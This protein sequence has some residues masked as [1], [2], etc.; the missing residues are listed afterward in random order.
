MGK[1]N[2]T[3]LE[4]KQTNKTPISTFQNIGVLMNSYWEVQ[5]LQE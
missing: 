2:K 5:R 3:L 1:K 4:L